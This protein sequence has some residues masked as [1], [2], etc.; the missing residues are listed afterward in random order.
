MTLEP[1]PAHEVTPALVALVWE[2]ALPFWVMRAHYSFR[3]FHAAR[4][5]PVTVVVKKITVGQANP[6]CT[7]VAWTVCSLLC[8]RQVIPVVKWVL[9]YRYQFPC[10][11]SQL[12]HTLAKYFAPTVA[13]NLRSRVTPCARAN[14]SSSLVK[15]SCSKAWPSLSPIATLT[16][17]SHFQQSFTLTTIVRSGSGV[18]QTSHLGRWQSK[19]CAS[20]SNRFA[21]RSSS[22]AFTVS[23]A[24]RARLRLSPT[25]SRCTFKWNSTTSMLLSTANSWTLLSGVCLST[26]SINLIGFPSTSNADKSGRT[27]PTLLFLSTVAAFST[28]FMDSSSL[29]SLH[30]AVAG[31]LL[32]KFSLMWVSRMETARS[33]GVSCVRVPLPSGTSPANQSHLD[34]LLLNCRRWIP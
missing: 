8:L 17:W 22:L 30:I 16:F 9:V 12:V 15:S 2:E 31:R 25:N 26:I 3:F 6:C 1:R 20:I 4:A 29:H 21:A 27:V 14:A 23:E 7:F 33:C 19:L 32:P 10:I 28:R 13:L 24:S 18:E 34:S 5:F 11:W